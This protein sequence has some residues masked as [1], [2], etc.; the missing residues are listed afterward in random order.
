MFAELACQTAF[1][2]HEGASMPEELVEQAHSLGLSA[3]GVC[4]RDGVYGMV[5]AWKRGVDL[6]VD[7]LHGALLTLRDSR[8]DQVGKG[9]G[10][11]R[12]GLV[13]VIAYTQD[14]Q[15]WKSL[16]ELLSL[17][18]ADQD[19][20][21]S[22]LELE[23]LMGQLDGLVLMVDGSWPAEALAEAAGDALYV[24]TWRHL[25]ASDGPREEQALRL[26]RRIDRP[27][28]A[29]NRPL[30]HSADRQQLQD[31]L[32]CIRRRCSID[33]AGLALQ[34]NAERHLKSAGA[35][36]Q[37]FR[38]RPDWI[39][40]SLE[41]AERCT[42]RLDQLT[43]AYPREVVPGGSPP[44]STSAPWWTR[45]CAGAGRMALRS[46]SPPRSSTSSSSS[47]AW[48]SRPTS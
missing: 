21:S 30:M 42:F 10:P 27:L 40:R 8:V 44:C 41:I 25:R 13:E 46:R 14:A 47:S 2:F 20:G 16:C 38:D 45:G 24:H 22:L 37:L 19:K 28:V 1:S 17:G 26:A 23:Q 18:R 31:V 33:Q 29:V 35:M 7:V 11:D 5:R 48:S 12:S 36:S 32:T 4:D 9:T 15:G 39:R 43:Y 34:S 3:L 6:G